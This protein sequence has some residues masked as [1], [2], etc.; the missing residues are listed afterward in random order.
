MRLAQFSIV[1]LNLAVLFASIFALLASKT[2]G[3]FFFIHVLVSAA[4]LLFVSY[5]LLVIMVRQ[6]RQGRERNRSG[7]E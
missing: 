4:I 7:K 2:W 1:E 5:L 3:D 6:H